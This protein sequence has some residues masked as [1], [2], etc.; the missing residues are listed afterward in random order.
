[1]SER[2]EPDEA[3]AVG[4]GPREDPARPPTWGERL[5]RA[6][7]A[8]AD[9]HLVVYGWEA[10]FAPLF[11]RLD[12]GLTRMGTSAVHTAGRGELWPERAGAG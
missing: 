9:R 1:M 8:L 7:G 6:G 10:G 4:V 2:P 11:A 3:G 12:R 5:A